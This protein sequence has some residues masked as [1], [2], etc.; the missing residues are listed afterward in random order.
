MLCNVSLLFPQCSEFHSSAS[1]FA[2]V[3]SSFFLCFQF[4]FNASTFSPVL[5]GVALK[6]FSSVSLQCSPKVFLCS[7]SLE[8]FT[9]V[10]PMLSLFL[11]C[12][13]V[14]LRCFADVLQVFRQCFVNV[15]P[16]S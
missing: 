15:S 7:V 3:R 11:H 9:C 13:S 1:N 14:F 4:L 5:I 6:C 10:S 12:F 2:L 16:V 8:C